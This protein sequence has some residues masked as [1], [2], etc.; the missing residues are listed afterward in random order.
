MKQGETLEQFLGLA[1]DQRYPQEFV[2]YPLLKPVAPAKE[3]SAKES[4]EEHSGASAAG[5]L[6]ATTVAV[7]IATVL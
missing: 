5:F 7:F 1:P 6:A 2:V 3:R 4:K